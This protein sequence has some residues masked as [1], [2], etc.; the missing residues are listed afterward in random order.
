MLI[1]EFFLIFTYNIDAGWLRILECFTIYI[2]IGLTS[3][4]QLHM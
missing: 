3:E 4:T 1:S 2:L